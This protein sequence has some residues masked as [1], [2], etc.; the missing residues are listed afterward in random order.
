MPN[1]TSGLVIATPENV[2]ELLAMPEPPPRIWW[3]KAEMELCLVPAGEFLMGSA[4]GDKE[5]GSDEKP[6]HRVYLSAYYIG[7]YPVTQAQYARFVQGMGHPVPRVE[8][9]YSPPYDWDQER[10]APPHGRENHPVVLVS[11]DDASAFCR[12]AGL[13]LPTEAEWEK[14]AR[15]S[16]DMRMYPWGDEAPDCSRLNFNGCIG[17]T[18]RVGDYP[19][20][21]SPY[22][23]AGRN[24]HPFEGLLFRV[25]NPLGLFRLNGRSLS[26]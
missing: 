25:Y 6:Q 17:D 7:R 3:E 24:V 22:G 15:G 18:S 20:G 10:K 2:A 23:C 1:E 9:R 14:T 4:E 11:W 21:A 16:A 8:E 19:S 13:R 5:A 26:G 12:W